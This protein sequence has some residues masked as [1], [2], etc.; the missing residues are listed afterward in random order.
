M[1]CSLKNFKVHILKWI[2]LIKYVSYIQSELHDVFL[3]KISHAFFEICDH[4]QE[5]G[6]LVKFGHKETSKTERKHRFQ[7][8][9]K[10]YGTNTDSE[11]VNII[12]FF[13]VTCAK[14]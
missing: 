13:F 10:T 1:T 8:D 6:K 12:C 7:K 11:E 4:K 14:L 5:K 3:P 2:L 9:E